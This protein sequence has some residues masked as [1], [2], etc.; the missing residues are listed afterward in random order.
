MLHIDFS[1][2]NLTS[3]SGYKIPSTVRSLD[4]SNNRFADLSSV[5]SYITKLIINNNSTLISLFG[6]P[7]N[8]N[9]LSASNCGLTTLDHISTEIEICIAENNFI[10]NI[11]VLLQCTKLLKLILNNNLLTSLNPAINSNEVSIN[12][13][14]ITEIVGEY[15]F[16]SLSVK[17]N[18]ISKI[19]LT[20][21][22]IKLLNITNT[23]V[24]DLSKVGSEKLK[25]IKQDN[26]EITN[27]DTL[28]TNIYELILGTGEPG[29]Y[30]D[31][32]SDRSSYINMYYVHPNLYKTP[33]VFF[34]LPTSTS[35]NKFNLNI[36]YYEANDFKL[37][38]GTI[39]YIGYLKK[40]FSINNQIKLSGT[41]DYI[42]VV[43]AKNAPSTI[44]STTFNPTNSM[45]ASSD[46]SVK[47]TTSSL[48]TVFTLNLGD[49]VDFYIRTGTSNTLTIYNLSLLISN[50]K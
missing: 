8:L 39:I 26:F 29:E 22:N 2:K 7:G 20:G 49:T 19:D 37:S 42:Q 28:P 25:I 5:P 17:K 12:N 13:N 47:P 14:L 41:N 18:P 21:S 3:L 1:N 24:A 50:I 48:I 30:Y 36:C 15:K 44:T 23:N 32:V 4:L 31:N 35:W 6:C 27:L 38:N 46:L 45:I 16:Y 9:H 10:T 11:D 34:T 40:T 33:P 43:G